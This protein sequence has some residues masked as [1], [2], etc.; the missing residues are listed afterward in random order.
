MMFF[1]DRQQTGLPQE[2]TR[3]GRETRVNGF[4]TAEQNN[5]DHSRLTRTTVGGFTCD[6]CGVYLFHLPDPQRPES[7]IISEAPV[8][9]AAGEKPGSLR[10]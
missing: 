9:S 10:K 7:Y 5:C 1:Q 2:G 6:G 3:A 8:E 4:W